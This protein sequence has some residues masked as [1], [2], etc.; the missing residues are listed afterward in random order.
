METLG[1][2]CGVCEV[3]KKRPCTRSHHTAQPKEFALTLGASAGK[4]DCVREKAQPVSFSIAWLECSV[5]EQFGNFPLPT[6]DADD[7]ADSCWS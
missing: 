3:S 5:V 7:S 1:N 2:C 6:G 4:S